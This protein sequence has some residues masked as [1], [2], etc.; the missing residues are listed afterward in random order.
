MTLKKVPPP[1]AGLLFFPENDPGYK[2]FENAQAHPFDPNPQGFSRVNAWWLADA[3]LLAYWDESAARP[4]WSTAG[5]RFQF[6]SN[7]GVQCHIGSTDEFVIVAFRGTQ[8]DDRHDLLTIARFPTKPWKFGGNVQSGFL[9]AH[10]AIWPAIDA[11]LKD[12]SLANRPVWFA[13][14]SF[15]A[16]LA[17]LSMDCFAAAKGLYTIGSPPVGDRNFVRQFDARH[18]GRCFRYV[19]HRDLVVHLVTLLPI[20]GRHY[21]HVAA[22]RYINAWGKIS[23]ASQSLFDLW[24]LL[25]PAS[26]ARHAIRWGVD[27]NLPGSLI[28]HTPRRYAVYIWNDYDQ[29]LP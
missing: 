19:N 3:A 22:R 25:R 4:I 11:A 15:G 7:R 24:A 9:D 13:G 26:L 14:H 16:A 6:V 8:P 21:K 10:N 23:T 27:A 17:T 2:H 1:S 28:D 20:L 5:L 18:T 29:H 12:P